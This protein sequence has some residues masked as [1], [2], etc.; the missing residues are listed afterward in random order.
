MKQVVLAI[1][2]VAFLLVGCTNY[3]LLP[4]SIDF[5]GERNGELA[6]LPVCASSQPVLEDS[7]IYCSTTKQCKDVMIK[8]FR[9]TTQVSLNTN[10]YQNKN[11]TA[12][13]MDDYLYAHYLL[14]LTEDFA[15][16]KN[17][18]CFFGYFDPAPA[19]RQANDGCQYE[20]NVRVPKNLSEEVKNQNGVGFK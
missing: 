17:N 16:C 6:N 5:V 14:T 7:T 13:R 9:E 8:F 20:F 12:A 18:S 1:F 15:S 11:D 4:G 3:S 19:I 10:I 2:V